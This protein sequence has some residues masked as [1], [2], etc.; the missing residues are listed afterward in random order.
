MVDI[1]SIVS[2]MYLLAILLSNYNYRSLEAMMHCKYK[3]VESNKEMP[4]DLSV[5]K[6]KSSNEPTANDFTI[7]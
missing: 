5:D 1:H 7:E 4:V 6:D 2:Q 3:D